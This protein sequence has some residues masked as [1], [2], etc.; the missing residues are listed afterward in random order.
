[1][2]SSFSQPSSSLQL[3]IPK[4]RLNSIPL[5]PSSYPGRLASRNSTLHLT[6]LLLLVKVK[7]TLRLLV[8]QSVRLGVEP[9]LGLVTRY[10]LL[11]DS[12]GLVFVGRPLWRE[13][14]SVF[15]ICCWSSPAYSFS[16]PSQ[17]DSWPYF[18]VSDLRLPF[19]SPPTTRMVTVEVF[20]PTSTRACFYYFVC[21]LLEF[22]GTDHTENRTSIVDEMCLPRRCQL[23]DVLL[24]HEFASAGMC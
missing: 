18:T 17:L 4:T 5:L 8:S 23:I 14:G 21:F 6:T 10:L 12:H 3:P 19:S 1:M 7:V 20:Y 11:F 2:R 24:F 22:F 16:G 15:C 9:H 13:D